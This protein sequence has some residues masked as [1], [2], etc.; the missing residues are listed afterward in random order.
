[1]KKVIF[2]AQTVAVEIKSTQG[3]NFKHTIRKISVSIGIPMVAV[4]HW[5]V[6]KEI[7]PRRC[8]SYTK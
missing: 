7:P 1:M 3:K 6:W 2:R 4:T 5:T 8:G